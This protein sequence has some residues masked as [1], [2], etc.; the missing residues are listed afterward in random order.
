MAVLLREARVPERPPAPAHRDRAAHLLVQRAVRRLPDVLGPRHPHVGGRR[1][2]ARRRR[3]LDPRGRAHPVDDAGQGPLPVLRA[4]ARGPRRATS[5]FS[6]DTPWQRPPR[7]TC[8]TP[9]CAART[10]RSRSSGR[11]ATAARCATR[12]ASRASCPT[13][14]ASTCRP[15]PTR[16]A[17]AG[18]ST[19]ARCRAR[20]CNGDRLKPEV[21][22]VL[23]HG[24]SIA[25]V[26]APEPRRCAGVLRDSSQ[27]TDRE[28]KIAAQVLREIRVRL[29][30]LLQV[31]L[32]Y[33]DL[34]R[35]PARSRAARRSASA[36]RRRS[37]RA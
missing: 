19:C 4:A 7:S 31:G 23:V 32:N 27:L 29:D 24:H 9:C 2:H 28:A 15:S 25:D 33:L 35:R 14:S 37:A 1:A 20:S 8:R 5:N 30:F 12:P 10:T 18:R 6:L 36:S 11:T 34:A 21:L 22:A 3:A 26:V 16:S 13:S 17:S